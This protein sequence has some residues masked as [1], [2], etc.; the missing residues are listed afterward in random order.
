MTD[1]WHVYILQCADGVY[2]CGIA[3]DVEKRLRQHNG[4][5]SGGARF[6][7]GRRPVT[8]MASARCQT[9]GAALR[10]EAA[11]KKLPRA[12]K[13]AALAGEASCQAW[14]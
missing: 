9:H 3:R 4:E 1:T 10:L 5:I 8:L 14:N 12:A 2:Y 13:L 6:T 7:S 11:I